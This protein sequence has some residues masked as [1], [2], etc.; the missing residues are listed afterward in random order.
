MIVANRGKLNSVVNAGNRHIMFVSRFSYLGIVLD[1][2]MLLEPLYKNVC[3]I[4]EQNG[5]FFVNYG[6]TSVYMQL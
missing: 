5:S 6:Y 4:I 2:E 1:S 3:R